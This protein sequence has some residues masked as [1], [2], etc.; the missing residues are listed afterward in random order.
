[1]ASTI[2]FPLLSLWECERDGGML[3]GTLLISLTPTAFSA[4]YLRL[5]NS[6]NEPIAPLAVWWRISENSWF[7]SI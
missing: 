6:A 7:T 1:M 2:R 5:A 3:K 4:T